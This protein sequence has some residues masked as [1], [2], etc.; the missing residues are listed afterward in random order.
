M[1][2]QTDRFGELK[3]PGV[4]YMN[5]LALKAAR[6]VHPDH[7]WKDSNR[8]YRKKQRK[9]KIARLSRRANRGQ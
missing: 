5:F 3:R 2:H 4:A 8:A 1:F 9:R 6:L 7:T